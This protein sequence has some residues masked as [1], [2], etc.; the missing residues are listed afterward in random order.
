MNSTIDGYILISGISTYSFAFCQGHLV[1]LL[2]QVLSANQ[3]TDFLWPIRGRLFTTL[4]NC[5]SDGQ[6]HPERDRLQILQ[7][8]ACSSGKAGVNNF[9]YLEF[10]SNNKDRLCI[11]KHGPSAVK[12]MLMSRKQKF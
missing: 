4:V 9:G 10:K 2:G 5:L 7:G 6:S 1:S 11:F 8:E 3:Q 12:M